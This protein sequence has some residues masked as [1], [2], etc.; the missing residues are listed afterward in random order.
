VIAME[1]A[2]GTLE[3]QLQQARGHGQAGIPREQLLA[4]MQEAARGID[5]LNEA[6]HGQPPAGIQHRDIKPAN[7]LL[8]GGCVK[9]GDFG[10]AKALQQAAATNRTGAMTLAYAAPELCQG[11]V[12]RHVDQYALAVSYCKLRGGRLP[13]EGEPANIVL[14]HV[15]REPDLSMLP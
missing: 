6:R 12:S 15:Q 7:L 3:Q 10:L 2:E 5:Y 11:Q 1:L 13:F 14:G 8:V 9:V 4:W